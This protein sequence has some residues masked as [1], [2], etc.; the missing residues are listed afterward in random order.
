MPFVCAHLIIFTLRALQRQTFWNIWT[1]VCAPF[2]STS[3]HY[4]FRI[5]IPIPNNVPIVTH[6][7]V[8]KFDGYGT[9]SR[10]GMLF[11]SKASFK[12]LL[13]ILISGFNMNLKFGMINLNCFE[14]HLSFVISFLSLKQNFRNVY[15]EK[16]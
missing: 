1:R 16:R 15:S 10:K 4:D 2:L 12:K 5:I 11:L 8:T 9:H 13:F 14:R 3:F 6:Y 7:A